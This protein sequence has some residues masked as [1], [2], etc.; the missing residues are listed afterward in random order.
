[1]L[2]SVYLVSACR[3]AVQLFR[4]Q[5][6]EELSMPMRDILILLG[7]EPESREI[8]VTDPDLR[9][10]VLSKFYWHPKLGLRAR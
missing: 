1:M 9:L 3:T 8:Y 2:N 6:W 4:H 5:N 10:M 7:L